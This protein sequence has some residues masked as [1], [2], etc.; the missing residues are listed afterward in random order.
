M[1]DFP[2]SLEYI[3]IAETSGLSPRSNPKTLAIIS[4]LHTNHAQAR[5]TPYNSS[6]I[7]Y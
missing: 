2:P 5:G 1:N 4:D 7:F 3:F 6:D